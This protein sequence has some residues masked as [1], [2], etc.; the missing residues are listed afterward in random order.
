MLKK[1]TLLAMAVGALVALV[2][3]ATSGAAVLTD[4]TNGPGTRSRAGRSRSQDS[5]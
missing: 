1:L 5:R 4:K 2:V 3:P